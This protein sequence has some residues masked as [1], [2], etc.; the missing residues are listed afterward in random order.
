MPDR[1]DAADDTADDFTPP[2]RQKVNPIESDQTRAAIPTS[3]T[4]TIRANPRPRWLVVTGFLFTGAVVFLAILALVIALLGWNWLR[5]PIS[6]W[7]STASGRTFAINGDLD[8]ALSLS[9]R[10]IANDVVFGN[11]AWSRDPNMAEIKRVEMTIDLGK[12]LRGSLE[13]PLL[14]LSQ[15]RVVLEKNPAVAVPPSV[16]NWIFSQSTPPR[17][18]PYIGGLRIDEGTV[19]YRDPINKTNLA[20]DVKTSAIVADQSEYQLTIFGKGSFN[21][22]PTTIE[23]RGG[24]LL[25]LRTAHN[26][27]PIRAKATIG[28]TKASIDGALLDPLRLAGEQLNFHI[29][30]DSLARLYLLIGVPFPPTPPYRLAGFMDHTNKVWKFRDFTGRVGQSDLAGAIEIDRAPT[31]QKLTANLTS[32]KLLLADLGGFIGANR[33]ANSNAAAKSPAPATRVL[34][35][36]PFSLEKLQAADVDVKLRGE[37]IITAS[38]PLEKMSVHLIVNKGVLK[39]APLDFW[40][41]GGHLVSQIEMDGTQP[42]ISTRADIVATGL[43]LGKLFPTS[44]LAA[45]DTGAINGRAKLRGTGNSVS[46]MMAGADGEAALLMD[47]GSVGEL[48]M[49]LANLDVANS[50]LLLVGGD[51][52]IPVRCAV[53]N[54]KA[55]K[56]IFTVKDLVLDTTKVNMV[57]AGNINFNDESLHLRLVSRAKGFSLVTLRGPIAVTG[58]FESP[59]LKPEM[60]GVFT[61]G[62][63]AVALGAATGGLGALLPLLDFGKDQDSK[64]AALL[65]QARADAGVPTGASSGAPKTGSKEATRE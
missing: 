24:A 60:Q 15:P 21:G 23:A 47:G 2:T 57:G 27:Y 61:R 3:G 37:K 4:N 63:L 9:P 11:A 46:Q 62:G 65:S 18:F 36:E 13:V 33:A 26:P 31:P 30:G 7:V 52:Q 8:I 50:L 35:T 17:T 48:T 5:G 25:S 58:S 51:K 44:T 32:Q 56:G 42:R 53:A 45:A 19:V 14:V 20:L 49:R 43:R 38:L 29:E 28:A 55:E 59:S 40:I 39:L 16:P 10:V 64:C 41:A 34:P 22:M 1:T 54:F 12:L 6:T